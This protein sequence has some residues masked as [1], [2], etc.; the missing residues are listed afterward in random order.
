MLTMQAIS[1]VSQDECQV[2]LLVMDSLCPKY[3]YIINLWLFFWLHDTNAQAARLDRNSKCWPNQRNA[4]QGTVFKSDITK[5]DFQFR[6]ELQVS[7][8]FEK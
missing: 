5:W 8:Y 3:Y 7:K 2:N 1:L 4:R 6:L